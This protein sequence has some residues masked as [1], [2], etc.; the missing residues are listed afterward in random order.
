MTDYKKINE[1]VHLANR[2]LAGCH[3]H[4]AEKLI[5]QIMVDAQKANDA[6][7]FKLAKQA[8]TNCQRFHFLD[9]LH[10]IKRIDPIQA[11]RKELS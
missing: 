6:N 9:A 7:T 11:Q 2:A 10:E 3:Y 8:L 5:T 1:L 4:R